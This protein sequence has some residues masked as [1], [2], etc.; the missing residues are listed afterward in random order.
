MFYT[1]IAPFGRF[2]LFA[3]AE[4]HKELPRTEK[5]PNIPLLISASESA[6]I[7]VTPINTEDVCEAS[8]PLFALAAG[9]FLMKV[10]GLPLDEAEIETASG[11]F[12]LLLDEKGDRVGVILSK[13]KQLSSNS[14]FLLENIEI[15]C[16]DYLSFGK[17]IRL[18]RSRDPEMF[19][20]DALRLASFRKGLPLADCAAVFSLGEDRCEYRFTSREKEKEKYA[21]RCAL[22]IASETDFFKG[23]DERSLTFQSG[24]CIIGRE[25]SEVVFWQRFSLL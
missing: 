20:P 2:D 11:I 19:S 10:R 4:L 9:A 1:I 3:E 18:V 14:K 22:A 7:K 12:K 8:D 17:R 25:G 15:K 24:E 23:G 5:C 21:L 16:S 13:C 6:D